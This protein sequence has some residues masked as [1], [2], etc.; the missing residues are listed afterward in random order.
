VKY[1]SRHGYLL[2]KFNANN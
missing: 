1:Y 2:S